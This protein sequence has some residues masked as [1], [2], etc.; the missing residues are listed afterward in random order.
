MLSNHLLSEVI[1]RIYLNLK[2]Y[3]VEVVD[4]TIRPDF[5]ISYGL[6]TLFAEYFILNEIL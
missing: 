4:F 5:H 3:L 6:R 2:E 1:L